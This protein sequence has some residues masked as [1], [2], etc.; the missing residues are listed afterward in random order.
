MSFSKSKKGKNKSKKNSL[1]N[2]EHILNLNNKKINKEINI[3]NNVHLESTSIDLLNDLLVDKELFSEEICS[4]ENTYN[5]IDTNNYSDTYNDEIRLPDKSFKD[6]LIDIGFDDD[7]IRLPDKSFKDRLIDFGFDNYLSDDDIL[8]AIKISRN[9]FLKNNYNI[10]D[11]NIINESIEDNKYIFEND[12]LEVL[13]L[14]EKEYDNNN[15]ILEETILNESKY[16]EIEKRI[17]SLSIFNKK[18]KTLCFTSNDIKIKK[19]LEEILDDYFNLKIDYIEIDDEKM[20]NMIYEVI[21]S[22]YLI[23][24]NKNFKKFAITKEEDSIIRSIFRYK[25]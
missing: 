5:N 2:N 16:I 15:N 7:E 23:P 8:H 22:Y 21:D 24:F 14:S 13:K 19:Y 18:I 9:D 4:K 3:D 25:K 6:R 12:I 20:Y 17:N 1:N 10:I 11:N